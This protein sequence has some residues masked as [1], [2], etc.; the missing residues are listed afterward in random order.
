MTMPTPTTAQLLTYTNVQMAAEAIYPVGFASGAI[1][2]STLT[3]GNNRSSKLTPTQATQ[4]A[5]EWQ[6]VEH[7]A[8]TST[9]F[10]GTLFKF[11]G[12][13][14]PARGLVKG[15]L[16]LSFRSTEFADDAARDTQA[17]GKLEIKE[18]GWAFGQIADMRAWYESLT[19]SGLIPAGTPLD[20]TGY[21]L[22]GHLATAFNLLYPSAVRST[23]T[24]NGAGVGTVNAGSSLTAVLTQFEQMRNGE[25]LSFSSPGAAARYAYLRAQFNGSVGAPRYIESELFAIENDTSLSAAERLAFRSALTRLKAVADEMDRVNAVTNA[26]PGGN[27]TDWTIDRIEAAQFDYQY[28]VLR[29]ADGAVITT[30]GVAPLSAPAD[31]TAPEASQARTATAYGTLAVS[32]GPVFTAARSLDGDRH[33]LM[34]VQAMAQFGG[35][36][37]ID[38]MPVA[39][40]SRRDL[41]RVDWAAQA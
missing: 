23:Y 38:A 13:D 21:S 15:Q 17:T 16:V 22:G 4:F 1:P 2:I 41:L 35:T 28:A 31:G 37:A 27:P 6:V 11:T 19:V 8:N 34:L 3:V 25:G 24:F 33:A 14:D 9:G 39:G 26:G 10:S 7:K 20:I 40:Y 29:L 12:D 30:G 36:A 32:S 18:F 5:T